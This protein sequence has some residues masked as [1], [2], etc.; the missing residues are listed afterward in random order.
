MGFIYKII[1]P[2]DK[3][4]IGQ[5]S[6]TV[7]KRWK[8]H[9]TDAFD[10]NKNHCKLLNASIRKYGT[11]DFII[12]TIIECNDND[13]NYYEMKYIDEL[14][15]IFPFGLNLKLGGSNGCHLDCVK[16]KISNSLKNHKVSL[17]SRLKLSASS[18]PNNLPMYII[19]FFKNDIHIGYRVCN[20]PNGGER[21][22]TNSKE[23][24]NLKLD[25]AIKYLEFLNNL[26]SPIKSIK[27][28]L[29]KYIQ[30]YKHGY[31]VNFNGI[32]KY[33][34]SKEDEKLYEKA[35]EYLKKQM[36]MEKVQRLDGNGLVIII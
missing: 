18:K 12:E 30:H 17:E 19:E 6:K 26:S 31:C 3:L 24:M 27:R 36:D 9:I 11:D 4:Y 28:T 2:N 16:Q 25:K 23:S 14:H 22:F 10:L 32:K 34:L 35:Q 1:A 15:S 20:H 5:T 33:F 8:E 29:P 13:L 21:K 7:Q